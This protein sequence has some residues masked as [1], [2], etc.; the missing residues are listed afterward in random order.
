MT[1]PGPQDEELVARLRWRD[2]AAFEA[3]YDRHA[4]LVYSVAY[5]VVGNAQAAEDVTQEVFLRLW[6]RP[7]LFDGSRGRFTT[8]LLSVARNRA[9]DEVRSAGR[10]LQREAPP[11]SGPP[12]LG[13]A[14][15]ADPELEAQL[16][17]EREAVRAALATLPPEQ[18]E[19]LVLAYFGGLTQQEIAQRLGQPLGTVKTR[20]RLGMKK[21]RD[22]L[23]RTVET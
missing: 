2:L 7:E 3:L 1:D 22:R 20:I 6:R 15:A 21:L 23:R 19:V 4:A 17:L 13:D 11:E 5:R 10:R 9:V 18:Q 14:S 12:D 16:A 8:W